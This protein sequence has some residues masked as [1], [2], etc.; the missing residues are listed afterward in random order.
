MADGLLGKCK[1]CTK[2]D[3]AKRA[4]EKHDE[5]LEYERKRNT[6]PHRVLA[7]K[8]YN[9]S[10]VGRRAHQKALRKQ[11]ERFPEKYKARNTLRNAVRDGKV[12]KLPCEVCGD[13]KSEGHH[14]DYSKPLD[15]KWLCNK[16]HQIAHKEKKA[17]E[18]I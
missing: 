9:R 8:E 16:H 6:A 15:V 17:R 5:I 4:L 12:V 13:P 1:E 14:E 7:R 18:K 3:V 11:I 10:D 2:Q